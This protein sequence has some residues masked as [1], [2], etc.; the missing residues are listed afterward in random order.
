MLQKPSLQRTFRLVAQNVGCCR[1]NGLHYVLQRQATSLLHAAAAAGNRNA[2]RPCSCSRFWRQHESSSS[3]HSA[4]GGWC[5][6][7][8][9]QQ[10]VQQAP[11]PLGRINSS[12]ARRIQ[13]SI[14]QLACNAGCQA[15]VW[16]LQA[17]GV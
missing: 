17:G 16:N 15:S 7:H 9:E 13:A 4:G 5:R 8:R 10:A 14:Q 6:R 3:R 1:L 11:A 12:K 2:R